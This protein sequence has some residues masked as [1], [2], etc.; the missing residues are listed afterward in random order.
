MSGVAV[1]WQS[2]ANCN[3][4]SAVSVAPASSLKG[5]VETFEEVESAEHL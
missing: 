1:C 5:T 4:G 3:A 2:E